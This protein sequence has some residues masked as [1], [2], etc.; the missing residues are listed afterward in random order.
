MWFLQSV[1]YCGIV[2]YCHSLSSDI[3]V[4]KVNS[5]SKQEFEQLE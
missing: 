2:L 4:S 3:K 1:L 5:K